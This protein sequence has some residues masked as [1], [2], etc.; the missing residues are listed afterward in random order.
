[1]EATLGPEI[2]NSW[3]SALLHRSNSTSPPCALSCKIEEAVTVLQ[4]HQTSETPLKGSA[5]PF[6]Q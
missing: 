6:L 5:G 2:L 3:C 1:M 4:A